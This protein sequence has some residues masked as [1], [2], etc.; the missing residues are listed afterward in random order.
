MT[1]FA[2]SAFSS[3]FCLSARVVLKQQFCAGLS[4]YGEPSRNRVENI[5]L[6]EQALKTG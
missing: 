5:E 4:N 3:P 1:H 6:G 2:Q